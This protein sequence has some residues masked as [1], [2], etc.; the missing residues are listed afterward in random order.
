M[1]DASG[2][3][4]EEPNEEEMVVEPELE[5]E[6]KP[7]EFILPAG[8]MIGLD[9][10]ILQSIERCPNDEM[11]RKMYSCILIIGSGMKFTGIE[12]WLQNRIAMQTPYAFRSE[13]LDIVTSPKDMDSANTAWKGAAIISCLDSAPELSI[14]ASEW[15]KHGLKILR[16][17]AMFMW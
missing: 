1:T 3:K 6:N 11:K 2:I 13:T 8:Q 12:K 16:E 17:K 14:S 10:A 7:K 15:Q 4:T 5:R 9:T